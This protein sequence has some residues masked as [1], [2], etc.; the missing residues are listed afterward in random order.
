MMLV[1]T[2]AQ[3]IR[4][5][6]VR[7]G[8]QE[9]AGSSYRLT[10]VVSPEVYDDIDRVVRVVVTVVGHWAGVVCPVLA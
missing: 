4:K 3:K 1:G 10:E 2:R 7:S 6:M 9:R 8:L 5:S